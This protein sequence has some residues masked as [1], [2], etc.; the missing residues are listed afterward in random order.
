[1]SVIALVA[2]T[3]ISGWALVLAHRAD[4]RAKEAETRALEA[5]ERE[6]VTFRIAALQRVY[7]DLHDLTH[8]LAGMLTG[9]ASAMAQRDRIMKR[10]PAVLRGV[11]TTGLG[12]CLKVVERGGDMD[13]PYGEALAEV[14][15]AIALEHRK[16]GH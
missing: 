9:D 1:V 3:C 10:L 11:D 8:A 13:A 6:R 7:D 4:R 16:A 5:E 14:A 2:S 15:E 12:A